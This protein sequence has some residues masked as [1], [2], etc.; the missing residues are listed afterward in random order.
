MKRI[1]VLGLAAA[2]AG[3]VTAQPGAEAIVM[4][5]NVELVRGCQQLG[6]VTADQMM[7]GGPQARDDVMTLLRNKAVQARATHVLTLNVGQNF[8][9]TASGLGELYRCK[10]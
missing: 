8:N 9:G 4:T 3:C 7:Y 2:L 10:R 1:V 6:Q 5:G